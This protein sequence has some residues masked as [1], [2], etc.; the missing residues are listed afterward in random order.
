MEK[1]NLELYECRFCSHNITKK[2]VTYETDTVLVIDAKTRYVPV[3][4]IIVPKKHISQTDMFTESNINTFMELND[5]IKL[6]FKNGC[7]IIINMG[8]S[9]GQIEDHLHIHI[10]GGCQM[11]ALG[12]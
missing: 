1:L 5:I 2:D 8:E 6:F 11:R 4:Y 12:L 3:H 9:S 7:R 10:F